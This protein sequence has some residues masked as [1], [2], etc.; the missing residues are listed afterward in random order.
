MNEE[1]KNMK[2]EDINGYIRKHSELSY[3]ELAFK[4]GLSSNAI[5]HRFRSMK[6]PYRVKV[7]ADITDEIAD[8]L[9]TRE[10]KFQKHDINKKYSK[11][12]ERIKQVETERD[13]VKSLA[14]SLESFEIK[15]TASLHSEAT[16][17]VLASD[18]HIEEKVV[19]EKV[20]FKNVHNLSI[21]EKRAHEF[22]VNTVKLLNKEQKYIPINTLILALLGDFISGNI[23]DEL[24]AN[25]ELAP[26][27]AMIRVQNWI[28][29]GI[30]YILA[31]TDVNLVI[32]CHVGNHPRITKKIHISN[33]QGNNLE[34]YMYHVLA[35]A[36]KNEKRI[37]W[38]IAESYHSYVTVYDKVLRFHHGHALKYGGGIGGLTVPENKAIA[39]WN[40]T[41]WADIDCHGHFHTQFDGGNFIANGSNI[42][43]NTFAITIKAG[44]EKPKQTFFLID[45]KRGKTVVV[46]IHYSV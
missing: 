24:L 19:G 21:A 42:G 38:L 20:N 25:C 40:K 17:V 22:F 4:T 14:E 46:P 39:Q 43:F 11:L 23:H 13:A 34:Y 9:Q 41:I 8:D 18:W 16:A 7:Y 6:L 1:N 30:K 31:N 5:R 15:A 10:D 33:E 28:N 26:V 35:N 44:F 29:S 45:K 3:D 32:P 37:T 36:F 12:L 27:A 2:T